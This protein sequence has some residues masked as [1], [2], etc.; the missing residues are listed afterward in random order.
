MISYTQLT[1]GKR[2][3][4]SI[5]L[6]AGYS[7]STL[8]TIIKVHKSTVS[9]SFPTGSAPPKA[10]FPKLETTFLLNSHFQYQNGC[11][12]GLFGAFFYR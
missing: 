10:V 3:E 2:Y 5:L 4:I 9:E 12:K 8:A 6:K 11:F 7:L 1:Q